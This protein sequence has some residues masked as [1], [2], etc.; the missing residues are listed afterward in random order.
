MYVHVPMRAHPGSYTRFLHCRRVSFVKQ[1]KSLLILLERDSK[2]CS[3]QSSRME[4]TLTT[5]EREMARRIECVLVP[6][7][8]IHYCMA[9]KVPTGCMYTPRLRLRTEAQKR[10]TKGFF[11]SRKETER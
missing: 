7:L 9:T 8:R 3:P 10:R 4:K 2:K 1:Y 11:R 5:K 6:L